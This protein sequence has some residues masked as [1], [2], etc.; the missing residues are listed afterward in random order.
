M[1]DVILKHNFGC[2][3]QMVSDD[4]NLDADYQRGMSVYSAL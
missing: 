1:S 3:A 4:I 2:I